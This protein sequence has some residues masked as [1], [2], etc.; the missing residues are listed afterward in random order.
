MGCHFIIRLYSYMYYLRCLEAVQGVVGVGEVRPEDLGSG[1]SGSLKSIND[2]LYELGY[3]GLEFVV[4]IRYT[5][6]LIR[7]YAL[8]HNYR[9]TG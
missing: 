8:R 5:V 3:F 6:I 9:T 7:A 1:V 4:L 2:V